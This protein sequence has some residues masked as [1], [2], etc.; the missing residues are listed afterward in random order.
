[1]TERYGRVLNLRHGISAGLI[2]SLI[3][4]LFSRYQTATLSYIA[5]CGRVGISVASQASQ[6]VISVL[7]YFLVLPL[8]LLSF[9]NV[10][11]GEYCL[12][13]LRLSISLLLGVRHEYGGSLGHYG[14]VY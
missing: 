3:Q 13:V 12:L 1:M 11:Q 5:N 14:G 2:L 7:N 9:A 6:E 4:M 10:F 8:T